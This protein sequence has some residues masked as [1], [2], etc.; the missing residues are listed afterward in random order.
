MTVDASFVAD[1]GGALDLQWH[2]DGAI[3][4]AGVYEENKYPGAEEKRCYNEKTSAF[5]LRI[6]HGRSIFRRAIA[7]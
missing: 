3:C 1:V 2:D 7:N 5:Q 4:G 6:A